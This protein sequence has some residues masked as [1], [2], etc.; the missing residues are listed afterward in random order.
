[1]VVA[2][3][4]IYLYVYAKSSYAMNISNLNDD[5]HNSFLMWANLQCRMHWLQF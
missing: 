1:M 4:N 2:M 5:K 3:D